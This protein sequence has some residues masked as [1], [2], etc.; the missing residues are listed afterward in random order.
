MPV[1]GWVVVRGAI[2]ERGDERVDVREERLASDG[3]EVRELGD[4]MW[5]H[6]RGQVFGEHK[7]L[8]DHGV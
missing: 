5:A 3:R 6:L 1:H 2:D 7:D 8:G 4:R